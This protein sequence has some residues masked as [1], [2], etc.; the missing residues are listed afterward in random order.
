ML[1]NN[2]IS[3]LNDNEL[4]SDI[5]NVIDLVYQDENTLPERDKVFSI[6][7]LLNPNEVKV[8]IIGQDPYHNTGQA[9]GM[10]FSVSD[11]VKAPPS[12]K[13]I[14]KELK[15]DLHVDHFDNND[16]SGWVRQGVLLLNTTLT[17][18]LHE[19]ESHI[20]IWDGIV[21][22]ILNKIN[23]KNKNIIYCL[24]GNHAKNLYNKLERKDYAVVESMHPSPFSY[25][26]GFENTKP[27]SKINV[28]LIEMGMN[29][30]DW[31]K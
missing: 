29:E 8:I 15:N 13:N 11:D 18:K 24:W 10:A 31:S 16:L 5:E 12:L 30:I 20:K 23:Q 25:K 9:N 7:S 2:W 21:L 14:F 27:F 6:F 3:F 1:P 22:K 28:S 17:V 19:P 4:I 26:K